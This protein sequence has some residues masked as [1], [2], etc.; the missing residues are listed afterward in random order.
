M[1]G[2]WCGSVVEGAVGPVSGGLLF[3]RLLEDALPSVV[4]FMGSSSSYASPCQVTRQWFC[5]VACRWQL[6]SRKWKRHY[7]DRCLT[8]IAGHAAVH[9]GQVSS[10]GCGSVVPFGTTLAAIRNWKSRVVGLV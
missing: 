9:L 2:C 7:L 3:D 5:D 4:S 6:R 10:V 8:T 1:G